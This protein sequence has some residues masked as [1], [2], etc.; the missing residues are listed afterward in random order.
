MGRE[1]YALRVLLNQRKR[2]SNQQRSLQG[3]NYFPP[4]ASKD[5]LPQPTPSRMSA[6]NESCNGRTVRSEAP[7]RL[8]RSTIQGRVR[9]VNLM[10][11]C[12]RGTPS[13]CRPY[14]Y[15]PFRDGMTSR[16]SALVAEQYV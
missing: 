7:M 12:R 16:A 8:A 10:R 9:L 5:Q 15:Q 1:D 4:I 3:A 2:R 13:A 11:R 14:P 6:A